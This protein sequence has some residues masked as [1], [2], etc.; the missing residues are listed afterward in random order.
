[1]E[2]PNSIKM[3]EKLIIAVLVL[4]LLHGYLIMEAFSFL[5]LD[6]TGTLINTAVAAALA[7]LTSRKKSVVC[8]WIITGLFVLNLI[9]LVAVE[10]YVYIFANPVIALMWV[11]INLMHAYAIFLLFKSY[12]NA[13]FASKNVNQATDTL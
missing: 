8:K 13:W 11:V 1:M 2:M 10:G 5:G 12:S 6:M 7:Y 4:S 3:F 9:I